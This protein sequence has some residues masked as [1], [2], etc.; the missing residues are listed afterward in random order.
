MRDLLPFL[1]EFDEPFVIDHMGY[2]KETDGLTSADQ[3]RLIEVFEQNDNFW[4]KL[5]GAISH[6]TRQALVDR[7]SARAAIGRCSVR[8]AVLGVRL[9][10][11]PRRPARYRRV[12]QPAR[13]LGARALSTG[14]R[15]W[16]TPP[17]ALLHRLNGPP[18]LRGGLIEFG[19]GCENRTHDIFITSEVLCRL[20]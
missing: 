19:A 8:P 16:W 2:M 7:G 18:D 9:A 11:P 4:I 6:R 13:R 5:S 20:S 1:A 17:T 3:A 10:A 15:S 12:P 14:T